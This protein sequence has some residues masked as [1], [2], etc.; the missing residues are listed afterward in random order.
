MTKVI[1]KSSIF[2]DEQTEQLHKILGRAIHQFSKSLSF[3]SL[4]SIIVT[5]SLLEDVSK[6]QEKH[7]LLETSSN[8]E[9]GQ[10]IAKVL[11]H[12]WNDRFKQTMFFS[13]RLAYGL[14]TKNSRAV[15]HYIHHELCHVHDNDYLNKIYTSENMKAS[16]GQVL[17]YKLRIHAD[18]IWSEYFAERLSAE[19]VT[20]ENISMDIEHFLHLVE[21]IKLEIDKEI[22]LYRFSPNI[23]KLLACVEESTSQ[24][25]KIAAT[26]LGISAGLKGISNEDSNDDL[27][28][29]TQQNEPIVAMI[30]EF[31]NRD[32][33]FTV[34]WDKLDTELNELYTSYPHWNDVFELDRL[35]EVVLLCWNSLGIF[36]SN[37]GDGLLVDVPMD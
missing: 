36:L 33:Y 18:L 19:T 4:E 9:H 7:N 5:E 10:V 12:S 17:E 20:A 34:I 26:L 6:Y 13:D 32:S 25:L 11:K 29:A 14:L 3:E 37:H 8:N 21:L 2:T 35:G 30:Q 24:L 27:H 31:K 16:R 22:N 15:Y 1:I 28:K 23:S